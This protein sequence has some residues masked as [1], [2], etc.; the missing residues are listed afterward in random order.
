MIR[1]PIMLWLIIHLTLSKVFYAE[2]PTVS[3]YSSSLQGPLDIYLLEQ[4]L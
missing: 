1:T 2:K 4:W 3:N